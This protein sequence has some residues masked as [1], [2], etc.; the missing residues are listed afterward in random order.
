MKRI[1]VITALLVLGLSIAGCATVKESKGDTLEDSRK[2][3]FDA[4]TAIDTLDEKTSIIRNTQP[5]PIH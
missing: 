1:G 4:Q 3:I 2:L 5:R